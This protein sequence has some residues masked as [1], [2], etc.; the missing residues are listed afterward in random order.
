[1]KEKSEVTDDMFDVDELDRVREEIADI[2]KCRINDVVFT[3]IATLN[4]DAKDSTL[5]AEPFLEYK[6]EY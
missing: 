2:H 5:S 6:N 4:E 3:S 1:M